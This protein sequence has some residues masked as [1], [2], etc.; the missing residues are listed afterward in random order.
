MS[1]ATNSSAIRTI[2]GMA[3]S[4]TR[5]GASVPDALSQPMPESHVHRLP[6]QVALPRN[7][8]VAATAECQKK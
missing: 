7:C 5:S 6:S 4:T 3:A 1:T 8:S 2:T